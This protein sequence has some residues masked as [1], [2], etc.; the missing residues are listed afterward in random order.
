VDQRKLRRLQEMLGDI[1]MA[2]EERTKQK[3]YFIDL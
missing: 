1:E 3:K 2:E